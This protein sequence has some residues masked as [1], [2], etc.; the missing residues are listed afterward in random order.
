[1]KFRR[2]LRHW[3]RLLFTPQKALQDK[4]QTFRELL[5]HDQKSLEILSELEQLHYSGT[6]VEWARAARLAR[7]LGWSVGSLVRALGTM[8][9]GTHDRLEAR[10]AI[11]EQEMLGLITL[12]EPSDEPPYTIDIIEAADAPAL[13][14]GKAQTLGL[15]QRT[16]ELTQ[17]RGFVI[18][19]HAGNLLINNHGL[20]H[21]IDELLAEITL[22]REQSRIDELSRDLTAMIEAVE[23]PPIIIDELNR[24][25][26]D[27]RADGCR[28]PWAVRSSAVGEDGAFSFAGQ[29]LSMLSVTDDNLAAAWKTVLASKYHPG[30]LIYRIRSGLADQE[31]AMAVIV[32]EM[33]DARVGGVIYS[34]DPAKSTVHACCAVYAIS[35]T[36]EGLVDGRVKPEVHRFDGNG[37]PIN[38]ARQAGSDTAPPA[39]HPIL[40]PD[41]GR[42]LAA[43]GQQLESLFGGPQDI[44]WCQ[45][46]HGRCLLLQ[47]RPL[48]VDPDTSD[49]EENRLPAPDGQPLLDGGIC[50]APGIGAG[51]VYLAGDPFDPGAVP[52]GV[53]LVMPALPPSLAGI[54]DRLRAV[55]AEGGSQ[56]SHFATIAREYGLPVIAGL[57]D[58]GAML[59][60]GQLVIVHAHSGMVY[61]GTEAALSADPERPKTLP[62]T[63]V[64]QRLATLIARIAPLHLIDPD[65]PTFAPDHCT[66]MHD[67]IRYAHETAMR[68]MFTLVSKGKRELG[69]ARQLQSD[70]PLTLSILDLGGGLTPTAA[71][72]DTLA[73][74]DISSPL[75]HA[76]WQGLSHPDITWH[77]GL[78][79]LDWEEADRL[80]AGIFSLSSARLGSYA[81]IAPDYLHLILRFGYHFAMLDCLAGEPADTNYLSFR[82]K[83]GGGAYD[84]RVRRVNLIGD[85]LSEAGFSVKTRSDLLDARFD[86][87]TAA[88]I[89]RRLRVLGFI[90]GKCQLLDMAIGSLDDLEGLR[91]SLHQP[92]PALLNR[93]PEQSKR[94]P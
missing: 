35:G 88:D 24:R 19:T 73:L 86:R 26:N 52:D 11:L 20:R 42:L 61:R 25:L 83:G 27:L 33:I 51:P 46:R 91:R 92:L 90:Q 81:V 44:E 82:F 62:S 47:C 93:E 18:T 39:T 13:A 54:I 67:L 3:S 14:G 75:F 7:G 31:T 79:Y 8:R 57:T 78:A 22:D 6:P 68:E 85:L 80:S 89:L 41:T 94:H 58:A 77:D 71:K 76:C 4:Y 15:L 2:L 34:R 12:P 5:R 49:P 74:T 1:M 69:A 30:A 59:T 56:A 60:A 36:A 70:L 32:M 16:T 55:I 45:D 40:D 87:R 72:R 29:Y 64:A 38:D 65:G 48:R 63:P 23:I 37:K 53:V 21:Q 66:S 9:P 28:G 17:P 50:A 10:W 84:D 43:W